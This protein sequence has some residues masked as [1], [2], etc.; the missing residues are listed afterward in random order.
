MYLVYLAA[1]LSSRF[2]G[3]PKL[4]QKIG[5]NKKSLIEISL[6][7]ALVI[8]FNKIIFIV[9]SKTYELVKKHISKLNITI[10]VE[11]IFQTSNRVKPWGTGH[12]VSC[13]Y[14]HVNE[15]FVLCNSDD[16][17]G[18]DTFNI[19]KD[20]EDTKNNIVIGY[21]LKNALPHDNSYVNRGFINLYDG[22]ITEKLNICRN[23]YNENEL[24]NIYVSM[25]LFILQP[26]ILNGLFNDVEDF[27][28]ENQH[29]ET[30]EALLP[31]FLKIHKLNVIKSDDICIGITYK[32]DL[33]RYK[34]MIL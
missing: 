16:L 9:S 1:G 25:N 3:E 11:F 20:Y 15:S 29:N 2:G 31:N 14:P 21:K 22:S 4:L 28:K 23:Y 24:N 33:K 12:A 7:Q 5:K 19:L 27:M 18:Y 30:L 10:P 26:N 32:D 6:E 34:S 8:N 13:L 17:Y